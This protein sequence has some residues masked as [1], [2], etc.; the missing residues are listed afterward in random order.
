M[1]APRKTPRRSHGVGTQI[2]QILAV[3]N[4]VVAL[5]P[6]LKHARDA[7]GDG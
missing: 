1:S 3:K 2:L 7:E 6:L 5:F 4:P